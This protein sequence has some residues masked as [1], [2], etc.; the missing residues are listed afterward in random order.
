[1]KKTDASAAIRKKGFGRSERT[2][3]TVVSYAM[4]SPLIIG[5][6]VFTIYPILWAARL[7]LFSYDGIPSDTFFVGLQN[8]F[9]AFANDSTFWKTLLNSFIF[10]A[11]KIPIEM[12]LALIIAVLL[13][14]KIKGRNLF[15]A[16]YY[17]PTIISMA[18]VGLVFSSMFGYYG[19]INNALMKIGIISEPIEWFADK[20]HAMITLV[21][22]SIWNSIGL[23]ILYFLAAVQDVPQ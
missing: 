4:L 10:M 2:K 11:I 19:V 16:V 23:N 5:F 18:I 20:G 8:Y 22:A 12:P 17:M 14:R 7:S 6:C 15:R 3:Q 21:V 9:N 1:M 13:N